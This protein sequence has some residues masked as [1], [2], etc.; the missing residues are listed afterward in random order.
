MALVPRTLTSTRIESIHFVKGCLDEPRTP[1]IPSIVSTYEPKIM[2]TNL[3]YTTLK[4]CPSG[5][6]V[7][8]AM[9]YPTP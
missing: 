4:L 8:D 7:L 6:P 5:C 3:Y 9:P 2:L 1:Q